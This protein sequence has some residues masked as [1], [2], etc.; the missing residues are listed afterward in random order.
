ME[1][2]FDTISPERQ[3]RLLNPQMSQ[4]FSTFFHGKFG[5]RRY[6][7]KIGRKWVIMRSN[8]H[9]ARISL[10]KF[11]TLAFVQWRRDV[12]SYTFNPNKKRKRE[13]YKDFG[14]EKHPRDY[15]LDPKHL[16]WK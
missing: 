7:I 4:H 11:K 3:E 9:R 6:D 13:W 16:L 2:L 14:F 1:L 15:V 12:E 5:H 8:N 10:E